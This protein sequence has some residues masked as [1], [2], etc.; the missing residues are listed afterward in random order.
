MTVAQRL[1]GDVAILDIDGEITMEHRGERLQEAVRELLDTGHR[2][3]LLNL[4]QVRYIDS[5]GLGELLA[6]K[7]AV[8]V[9]GADLKLLHP[10]K[11]IYS[12]L[13]DTSLSKVFECFDEEEAALASFGA[14]I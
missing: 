5:S 11:K 13:A 9:A 6:L 7:K 1:S 12:V 14:R 2:R 4:E 3:I 10:Q 8:L